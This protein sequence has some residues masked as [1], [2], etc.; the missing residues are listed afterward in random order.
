MLDLPSS[1]SCRACPLQNVVAARALSTIVEMLF[2]MQVGSTIVNAAT[3]RGG[4]MSITTLDW[5][6]KERGGHIIAGCADSVV[7]LWSSDGALIGCFGHKTWRLGNKNFWQKQHIQ[8][9]AVR[10]TRF[11]FPFHLQGPC[12]VW[13][14]LCARAC[15]QAASLLPRLR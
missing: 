4:T 12:L 6:Q 14:S 7:R 15:G 1:I 2:P 10:G 3:W 11:P 8:P 9:L 5:A 13:S